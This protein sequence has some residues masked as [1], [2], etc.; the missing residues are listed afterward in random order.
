MVL[1]PDFDL[2]STALEQAIARVRPNLV[3]L[4][5]PNNPTGK[6]WSAALIEDAAK[7]H[8]ECLVVVDE[9]CADYSS[10]SMVGAVDQL[11]NLVVVRS[12]SKLGMAALRVGAVVAHPEVAAELEKGRLPYN[13]DAF[14]R[15]AAQHV[16]DTRGEWLTARVDE[17]VRERERLS[18]E[19]AKLGGVRVFPSEANFVLIEVANAEAV[20]SG[21]LERR[22]SVKKFGGPEALR[23]CLRV[24]IGTRRENDLFFAALVEAL[25]QRH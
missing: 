25:D 4:D 7:R 17:V 22:V 16:L 13:V 14:A 20:W 5:R 3:V 19:L 21:L 2:S 11:Q 1:E 18:T 10:S 23:Q 12:L 24:T 6:L 15:L 9:A 8:P